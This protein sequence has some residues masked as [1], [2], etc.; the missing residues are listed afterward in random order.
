VTSKRSK[1]DVISQLKSF[2]FM[3]GEPTIEML[4]TLP[5]KEFQNKLSELRYRDGRIWGTRPPNWQAERK[6]AWEVAKLAKPIMKAY[7]SR[8]APQN[9]SADESP[10]P[11]RF[12]EFLLL[13]IPIRQ[14]DH[15]V[16]DLEEEFRSITVPKYGKR[17]ASIL[18]AWQVLIEIARAVITGVRGVAFG[19]IFAKLSK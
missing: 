18:Y 9:L 11:P 16:G 13:L 15:V 10:S 2:H 17:L 14:R 1:K 12:F 3:P 4:R 6:A 7:W 5:E 19:W 8:R